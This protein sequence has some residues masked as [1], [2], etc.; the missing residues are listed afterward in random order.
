LTPSRI[1]VPLLGSVS[2]AAVSTVA[3][4]VLAAWVLLTPIPRMFGVP[5]QGVWL[6]VLGGSALG[7]TLGARSARLS[8]PALVGIAALAVVAAGGLMLF[9]S[10]RFVLPR[11]LVRH[12]A[13][14]VVA[15]VL[16]LAGIAV[17]R[18]RKVGARPGELLVLVVVAA[19]G[20]LLLVLPRLH[21]RGAGPI[22][23]WL[24]VAGAFVLAGIAVGRIRKVGARPGELLIVG[25]VAAFLISDWIVVRGQG[26]RDLRLYLLAGRH[27]LD[28]GQPYATTL[29]T[30]LPSDSADLP[31]LY[32]PMTLPFFGV[33]AAL[34]E[35]PVILAWLAASLGASVL[36]LRAFGVRWW[37]IPVLLLWPPFFEGLWVGNVAV[38]A[39]LLFAVGPR[40]AA[41]LPLGALFKLQSAVPSLWLVRERRWSSLAVGV[42]LLVGLAVVTLP[43][44]GLE[45]WRAWVEALRLF[46]A[47]EGAVPGLYGAALPRYLP[48]AAYLAISIVAVGAAM[49]L[50][51]GRRGLARFG[52]AS[53]VA[54]PS[55]YR[56]GFLVVLPGLLGNGETLFWLALGLGFSPA[57]IGWWFTAA[58]AAVGTFRWRA[59][60]PRPEG[61]LHP[62]G[63]QAEPW[64]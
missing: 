55:L 49:V 46:Q 26:M 14:L 15:W 5:T 8:A 56:H 6:S 38:P 64:S 17:G 23:G 18:V 12:I 50:G 1:R 51:R 31:F 4:V 63:P 21:V 25:V 24:V 37:W 9:V 22:I 52:I 35:G 29:M 48:Y 7:V 58:I 47:F 3:I 20:L 33:L 42:G 19:G 44:V 45:S 2:D 30:S 32:P 28:G 54:S 41:A 34:P 27:F 40:L 16:V 43:F 61:T 36:A 53:V 62:L 39:L 59:L 13:W 57:S 11:V 10:F 60:G